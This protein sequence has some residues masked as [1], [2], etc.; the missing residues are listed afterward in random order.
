MKEKTT[1]KKV[2]KKDIIKDLYSQKMVR[3]LQEQ[4]VPNKILILFLI[5]STLAGF[6]AGFVHD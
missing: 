6:L 3:P 1:Q 2:P 4:K 5:L